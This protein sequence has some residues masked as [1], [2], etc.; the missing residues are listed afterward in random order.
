MELGTFLCWK[1]QFAN[2]LTVFTNNRIVWPTRRRAIRKIH[3]NTVIPITAIVEFSC[4]L[5]AIEI[6][7]TVSPQPVY[8]QQPDATQY[9]HSHPHNSPSPQTPPF[10]TAI[11][12]PQTDKTPHIDE[13]LSF[14]SSPAHEPHQASPAPSLSTHQFYPS[15]P[16]HGLGYTHPYRTQSTR[17][18][19]LA[20]GL[21]R[22]RR[23]L[24]LL[25]DGEA[26]NVVNR[27][28][29]RVEAFDSGVGRRVARGRVVLLGVAGFLEE[30][31]CWWVCLGLVRLD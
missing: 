30:V 24:W 31:W 1:A 17:W 10:P 11:S 16:Q 25:R 13:V 8:P 12:K 7:M 2:I 29:V 6:S 19:R 23:G 3:T 5:G 21:L 22:S 20:T 4:V 27:A 18:A 9:S 26:K 14:P 15:S 28:R